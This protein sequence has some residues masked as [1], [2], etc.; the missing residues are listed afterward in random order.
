MYKPSDLLIEGIRTLFPLQL[1][2]WDDY[3]PRMAQTDFLCGRHLTKSSKSFFF[4]KAPFGGSYALLGGLTAFL[5]TLVDYRFNADVA[6]AMEDMGYRKEFI[7][8]LVEEFK[9][10]KVDVYA[11]PEGSII[12][13]NEPAVTLEGDLVSIRIAE[14]MLLEAVNYPTLAMTKWHRVCLSAAPGAVLEFA[15]RRAQDPLRTSLYAHLAGVNVTSNAEI[16]RG[17]NI[18]VVGTMGHEWIQSFGDELEAFDKWLE[19]NPDRPVLLL[20]T[21]DTLK[22]GLPNAITAFKKHWERIMRA[23]GKPGVRNDSGDLAYITVEE[24]KTLDE[25]GLPGVSILETNDLDEYSIEDIKGQIKEHAP[26]A[27]LDP[28]TVISRIIWACGTKPGTCY[29][30]PSL[31][32]V[33]KLTSIQDSVLREKAVIKLARDNPIKT[34]IPGCNRS[35]FVWA[36]IEDLACCLIYN[37][38]EDVYRIQKAVHPD[39]PSKFIDIRYCKFSPRQICVYNHNNPFDCPWTLKDIRDN[40]KTQTDMLH[41]TVKRLS[42]PHTIKVSLSPSL[43]ELRRHMIE[44][45]NLIED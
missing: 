30:Q 31:G 28:E 35:A 17:F 25:A 41:W 2:P 42:N 4:R 14:G 24:R 38:K 29:D 20:D 10:V 5:R 45:G 44:M 37:H 39:D 34:S 6:L 16:R 13:P 36:G 40:V 15:R 19:H 18:P 43:Q 21:R 23:G 26:K 32:G 7:K 3:Y 9:Q 1:L 8:Y 33:A 22:S 11:P 27:D 12:L